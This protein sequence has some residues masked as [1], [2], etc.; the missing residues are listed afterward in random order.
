VTRADLHTH[1]DRSDGTD[2]PAELVR[3]AASKGIDVLGLTDHD[4]TDGWDEASEEAERVGVRLVRGLEI[5]CEFAD[6]GV[7]LLAYE[8]DPNYPPLADELARIREGRSAR[9]PAMLER[10][11]SLGIDIDDADLRRAA[12]DAVA[13]GRPHVADALVARGVVAD[14]TEAFTAYLNR[15]GPGYVRRYAADLTQVVG[16]VAEA[17]GVTVLAH[18]WTPRHDYRALD[19]AGLARLKDAGL[20][21]VEVD[22]QDHDAATREE[23]REVAGRLDLVVTG[24]SDYHG[25]GKVDHELGCNTTAPDQLERLLSAVVNRS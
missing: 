23:L 7:H 15:R 19:E 21:G 11:R 2:A 18:P 4:T 25:T 14:R 6:R 10:L 13:L 22:H 3:L 5:S 16:L 20:T 8:P 9:I 17:G 12:G 24:S 1:S